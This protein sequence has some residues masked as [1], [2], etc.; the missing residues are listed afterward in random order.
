MHFYLLRTFKF[1]LVGILLLSLM[2]CS[3]LP[4]FSVVN[5]DAPEN[6]VDLQY[7]GKTVLLL[8]VYSLL[9]DFR[10]LSPAVFEAL[11]QS[12][13]E[14]GFDVFELTKEEYRRFRKQA[15]HDVGA[16][17]SPELKE[18]IPEDEFVFI[19]AFIAHLKNSGKF[20]VLLMPELQL[21]VAQLDGEKLAWGGIEQRLEIYDANQEQVSVDDWQSQP[22]VHRALSMQ[23]YYYAKQSQQLEKQNIGL[24]VPYQILLDSNGQGRYVVP[25]YLITEEQLNRAVNY[26]LAPLNQ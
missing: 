1:S 11:A 9:R 6:K 14:R 10:A 2:A 4:S 8:P 25:Q 15:L 16:I 26:L 19:N 18:L 20:D 17:Y 3:S 13:E 12:L 23:M 5:N 7:S 21:E 24:S 22:E